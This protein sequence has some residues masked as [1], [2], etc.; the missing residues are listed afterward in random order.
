M[1]LELLDSFNIAF[2]KLN[3]KLICNLI[4]IIYFRNWDDWLFIEDQL[5]TRIRKKSREETN[6]FEI[7]I[8]KIQAN[9]GNISPASYTFIELS[10]DTNSFLSM[11]KAREMRRKTT[12]SNEMEIHE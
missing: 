4:V 3:S 5:T 6:D 12:K 10:F 9:V 2:N 7:I 8:E 1:L 11:L